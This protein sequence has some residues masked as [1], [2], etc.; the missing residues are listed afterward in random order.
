MELP[1]GFLIMRITPGYFDALGIPLVR[2]RTF[3]AQDVGRRSAGGA[4]QR[5]NGAAAFPRHRPNRP[6]SQR[7]RRLRKPG[8]VEIVGIVGDVVQVRARP[9]QAPT[10]LRAVRAEPS[11]LHV[12]C[13]PDHPPAQR[14]LLYATSKAVHAIDP[15]IPLATRVP[16]RRGDE[17]QHRG[18]PLCPVPLRGVRGDGPFSRRHRRVWRDELRREPAHRGNRHP[19]GARRPA[20]RRNVADPAPGRPHGRT[21][22]ASPA[23]SPALGGHDAFL[24]GWML[25]EAGPTDPLTLAVIVWW[26]SS[27]VAFL[28][29]WLPARRATRVDPLVALRCE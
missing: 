18:H 24:L 21:R 11:R 19:H 12:D 2:G 22:P 13:G 6:A 16:H 27:A 20:A 7:G 23:A 8:A 10:D 5:G 4:D 29:C 28:A 26:C 3:T 25:Y 1:P 9:A 17:P 15:D 14:D